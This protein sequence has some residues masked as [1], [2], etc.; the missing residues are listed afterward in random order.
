MSVATAGESVTQSA[1]AP[2]PSGCVSFSDLV[3]ARAQHGPNSPQYLRRLERFESEHGKILDARWPCGYDAGVALVRN[4]HRRLGVVGEERMELHRRSELLVRDQPE[5]ARLLLRVDQLGVLITNV[6]TGMTQ[7]IAISNLYSVVVDVSSFLE[8]KAEERKHREYALQVAAERGEDPSPPDL[9]EEAETGRA[10]RGY[11]A[12]VDDVEDYFHQAAAR[13]AQMIYLRGMLMGLAVVLVLTP[14]L[15]WLLSS[16]DVPGVDGA[17]FIGCLISGAFGAV[18]SVLIRMSN[19]KFSVSHEVGRDWV[20][21]LGAARPFIGAIFALLLYFA[22]KGEL[23]QQISLPE[24]QASEFAFFIAAGF[25]I[26]FS[27]RLA[28]EVIAGGEQRLGPISVAA[29]QSTD[30]KPASGRPPSAPVRGR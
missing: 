12:M 6:L 2:A 4:H 24:E 18:M 21:N 30:T 13:T 11:T 5:F 14:V 15:A 10:L 8:S 9:R 27:E 20:T 22:F 29:D 19:N 25:L 1:S 26:G 16:L 17:L 7:R 28:K 23:L 3:D